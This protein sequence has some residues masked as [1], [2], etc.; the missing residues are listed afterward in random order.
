MGLSALVCLRDHI[1][2]TYTL[3]TSAE[4]AWGSEETQNKNNAKQSDHY[5]T[6][7][8]GEK[9]K[10]PKNKHIIQSI[11]WNIKNV[12]FIKSN[13]SFLPHNLARCF[14]STYIVSGDQIKRNDPQKV[15]AMDLIFT[16]I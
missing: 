6:S 14:C 1:Y 11:F 13:T 4:E 10:Q 15:M 9:K 16:H 5:C 8:Q 2:H 12:S 7:L 3:L